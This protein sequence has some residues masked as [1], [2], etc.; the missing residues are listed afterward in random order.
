MGGDRV[1]GVR[2]GDDARAE[3]DLAALQAVGVAAPVDP[4]VMVADDRRQLRIAHGREHVRAIRGVTLDDLEL[5]VVE[6]PL[7]LR[8]SV[9]V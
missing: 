5:F 9:G 6:R 8:I 7:L 4:L 1:E 3:R 2:D